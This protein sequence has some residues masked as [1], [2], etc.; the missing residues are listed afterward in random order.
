M[1][2]LAII[3]TLLASF[4]FALPAHAANYYWGM[5]AV[6]SG[7]DIDGPKLKLK[8]GSGYSP[9]KLGLGYD[10]SSISGGL[11]LIGG[12]DL[13]WAGSIPLRLESESTVYSGGSAKADKAY[14]TSGA[15]MAARVES[16]IDVRLR[17]TQMFNLWFDIPVGDFPVKPYVGGGLGFDVISYEADVTMNKNNPDPSLARSGSKSAWDAAFQYHVGGGV[18]IAISKRAFLDLNARYMKKQDW[19]AKM[20]PFDLEFSTQAWDISLGFRYYF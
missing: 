19:K 5:G 12:I 15:P 3:F 20:S 13:G 18:C 1:K 8:S 16:E 4:C 2:R 10:D 11:R 7:L 14:S 6:L 9:Q 17:I